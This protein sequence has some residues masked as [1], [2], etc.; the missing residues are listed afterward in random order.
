MEIFKEEFNFN[1]LL[2]FKIIIIIII[3]YIIIKINFFYYSLKKN[4][5]DIKDNIIEFKFYDKFESIKEYYYKDTFFRPF[6]DEIKIIYYIFNKNNKNILS[7][8]TNVHISFAFN[9]KLR[10]IGLR[11]G[12][13]FYV[14]W[15]DPEHEVYPVKH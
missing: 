15:Y 12:D 4:N 1:N 7:N 14:L 5:I 11:Q 2:V 6:L 9:N 3:Y 8:T 10:I 13:Y